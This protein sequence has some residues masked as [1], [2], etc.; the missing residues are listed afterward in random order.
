MIRKTE[1][2]DLSKAFCFFGISDTH[3]MKSSHL[4][5]FLLVIF[6]AYTGCSE[7]RTLTVEDESAGI[8]MSYPASWHLEQSDYR[9]I[10][11]NDE[12]L[13]NEEPFDSGARLILFSFPKG[14]LNFAEANSL[15]DVTIQSLQDSFGGEVYKPRDEFNVDNFKATSETMRGT[16]ENGI[17]IIYQTTVIEGD[18]SVILS[19]A[20]VTIDIETELNVLEN[21]VNDID[22]LEVLQ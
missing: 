8:K 10:L 21:I 18:S 5:Y 6:L 13:L 17:E 16:N 3:P 20:E 1:C 11:A 19:L 9:F 15:L 7:P 14:S 12:A 22:F 4:F 2:F